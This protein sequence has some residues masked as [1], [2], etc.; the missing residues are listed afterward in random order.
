MQ[1]VVGDRIR[2]AD[3]KDPHGVDEARR[4]MGTALDLIE[5]QLQGHT[6][7]VG[8][9]FTMADCAAAPALYYANRVLPFAKTHP[10]TTQYLDCLMKR[11]SFARVL[12]EAQPY[13]RFF[14][15]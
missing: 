5:Q 4:L 7:S 10:I 12:D 2:P 3:R 15:Q 14:P 9:S 13:F 8:D 1:K 11:P 6:F